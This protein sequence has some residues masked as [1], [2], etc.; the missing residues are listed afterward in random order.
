[1]HRRD[2][3]ISFGALLLLVVSMTM[4]IITSIR[5]QRLAKLQMDF[6]TAVSHELRT[7]L[8]IISSAADNIV[9]GVVEGRDQVKQYGTVIGHQVRQLSGRVEQILLFA[10]TEHTAG[11]YNLQPLEVA[12]IIDASL[13]STEG[14]I[15]AGHVR[16][17]RRIEAGLPRVTGDLLALSQCV[18]N[19]ITNAFKYGRGGGWIGISAHRGRN[20]AGAEEVHISVSDR[21]MGVDPADLPHIFEPFYRSRSVAEAQIRGTGLGLS[22]AKRIAE[23]MK[24]QLT[25]VSE[26]G[27]G[28]TFTLHLP[29]LDAPVREA[30]GEPSG[31][32]TGPPRSM[33]DV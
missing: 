28:T 18:Q 20:A 4:L 10:A 19:L 21:G 5:A 15:E 22:L 1:M 29:A 17:E 24:G 11:R 3:A 27:H 6:V 13:A 12:D 25:V 23:A 7:P 31:A 8:S 33:L 9:Q 14:L 30:A 16:V 26:P 2:L 32:L